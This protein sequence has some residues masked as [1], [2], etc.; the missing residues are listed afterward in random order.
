MK[1]FLLVQTTR[2]TNTFQ[3]QQ[4]IEN[5]TDV[6]GDE[7][8]RERH[9]SYNSRMQCL[10]GMTLLGLPM[11]SMLVKCMWGTC[12]DVKTTS[13]MFQPSTFL[14]FSIFLHITHP[15]RYMYVNTSM[16]LLPIR[17]T[18]NIR[19]K[20]A[21]SKVNIQLVTYARHTHGLRHSKVIPYKRRLYGI[22]MMTQCGN[23]FYP[24][25]SQFN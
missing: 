18:L 24:C 14:T 20:M 4:C 25:R 21:A 19:W 12:M 17:D 15:Q 6:A 22:T 8:N 3:H 23:G 1:Y 7:C 16:E 9:P 5:S 2:K 10:S 13:N 11:E